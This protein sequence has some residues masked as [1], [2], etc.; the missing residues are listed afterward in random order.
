MLGINY[1]NFSLPKVRKNMRWIL[2]IT[3][4]VVILALASK[5]SIE[6]EV[7]TQI[8]ESDQLHDSAMKMLVEIHEAND[9]LL[10]EKYF[11][12]DSTNGNKTSSIQ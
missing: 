3:I 7:E 9:S 5:P 11:H 6:E 4:L 8:V 10:I 12:I 1:R 2:G